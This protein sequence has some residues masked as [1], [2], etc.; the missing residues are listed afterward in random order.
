MVEEISRMQKQLRGPRNMDWIEI[1]DLWSAGHSPAWLAERFG[2][3]QRYITERCAW[4]DNHF[5]PTAP[6]RFKAG[7][8]RRLEAAVSAMERGEPAE[9]E[10]AA[11]A[12]AAIIRA[13]KALEEWIMDT[14][15]AAQPAEPTPE[16]NAYDDPRAEL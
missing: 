9:A 1:H 2:L 11:R 3:G 15:T 14:D 6:V 4:V 7:L 12:L 13:A 8:I 10:R 16:A 5:P